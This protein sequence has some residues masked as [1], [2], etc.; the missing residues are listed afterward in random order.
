MSN[1]KES[2]SSFATMPIA[3]YN[4]QQ[5]YAMEQEWFAKGYSSFAL[6][7][8]AAWQ[9]A[10]RIID[11][12]DSK[13]SQKNRRLSHSNAHLATQQYKR[14]RHAFIWVGQGN[15]GGDGWLIALYLQQAGWQVKVMTVGMTAIDKDDNDNAKNSEKETEQ[16]SDAR[17]AKRLAITA[18]CSYLRF[19]DRSGV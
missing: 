9:M 2:L 19:E 13:Q 6:M 8:Q 16:I 10:Q 14:D 4:S 17:K 7:Q 15:N 11:I 12:E 18:G 3:L 5:V 1:I